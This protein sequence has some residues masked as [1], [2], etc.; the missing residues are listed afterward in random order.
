[1]A[2]GVSHAHDRT[3][4][5]VHAIRMAGSLGCGDIVCDD[6]GSQKRKAVR[7]LIRLA[8]AKLF[9]SKMLTRR[10]FDRTVFAKLNH[11]LHE[12]AARTVDASAPRSEASFALQDA[13][14]LPNSGYQ[15][16]AIC[17]L[18]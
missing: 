16:C 5:G 4:P 14:L 7:Q 1:M 12:A 18:G 2:D 10:E 9:L 8:G 6:L 3:P 13:E 17:F 15:A 11:L